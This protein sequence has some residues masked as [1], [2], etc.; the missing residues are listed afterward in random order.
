M[1][2]IYCANNLLLLY[3][4]YLHYIY[5]D[6]IYNAQQN[7]KPKITCQITKIQAKRRWWLKH[8]RCQVYIFSVMQNRTNN[9]LQPVSSVNICCKW[10]VWNARKSRFKFRNVCVDKRCFLLFHRFPTSPPSG[11]TLICRPVSRIQWWFGYPVASCL[12]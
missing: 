8:F 3:L 12:Y 2:C 6:N 1:Y 5:W 10:K 7:L 9:L 4:P 11:V